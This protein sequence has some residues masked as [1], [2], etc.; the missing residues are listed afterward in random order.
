MKILRRW[1]ACA[2]VVASL[3]C[4]AAFA[5]QPPLSPPVAEIRALIRSG[6]LDAAIEKGEA[7]VEAQPQ[8]ATA[9]QWL[10]HAY[11][12]QT[13]QASVFTK[14][15]WA[16][17]CR[18]AYEKAVE[19]DADDPQKR[20]DLLQYYAMAPGFLGGGEDKARAEADRIAALD[21]GYGHLAKAQLAQAA[22]DD[23]QAE[24][25][26]RA[27]LATLADKR[28]AR[29]SLANFYVARKRW[30]DARAVWTAALAEHPD[31]ATATYMLGRTAALSGEALDEGLA[32]LDRYL[33]LPEKD[34][35]IGVGPAHWRKGLILEK[36]GR[37]PEAIAELRKAVATDPSLA[38]AKKD[39]ERL[40]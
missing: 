3:L 5:Q 4:G 40:L 7:L 36:L 28:R 1:R 18:D 37:V 33:A 14:A 34:A 16:G 13:I 27:A 12:Q 24:R 15:S 29:M 22:E 19:L 25:E 9:W 30:A 38:D 6:D 26:L 21:A 8:D 20:L 2:L 39:L 35:E 31:D 11:G 10:G 23:A 17:K 32:H